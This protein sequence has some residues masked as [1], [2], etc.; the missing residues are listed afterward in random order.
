MSNDLPAYLV[1]MLQIEYCVYPYHELLMR[2]LWFRDG[3]Q[4]TSLFVVVI[5]YLLHQKL[6]G[7]QILTDLFTTFYGRLK[8]PVKIKI[9][10]SRYFIPSYFNLYNKKIRAS[11]LFSS[12]LA[13]AE[14]LEH[15]FRDFPSVSSVWE[16][17]HITWPS[18]FSQISF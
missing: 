15:I 11:S 16:E 13:L 5:G 14:T 12:C 10:V 4:E 18:E 2:I 3:A 6:L 7:I 17:L 9:T 1:R 8:L